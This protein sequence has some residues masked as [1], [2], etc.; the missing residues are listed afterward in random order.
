MLRFIDTILTWE[1]SYLSF[2]ITLSFLVAGLIFLF[3]PWGVLFKWTGRFLVLVLFGPQNKILDFAYVRHI[4]TNEQRIRKL[5][6]KRM[7][8]ARVVQEDNKKEKAF[9]NALFGK[10]ST[11]VP[12]IYWTR[13]HDFPLPSSYARHGPAEYLS[14]A[15]DVD[16]LPFVRGQLLKGVMIPRPVEAWRRNEA[17]SS[18]RKS[19]YKKSLKQNNGKMFDHDENT[20]LVQNPSG[21]LDQGFEVTDLYDE[22][23]GYVQNVLRE[24]STTELGVEILQN[25]NRAFKFESAFRSVH[26]FDDVD[27]DDD[28]SSTGPDPKPECTIVPSNLSKEDVDLTLTDW[29]C[30]GENGVEITEA[31]DLEAKFVQQ[32]WRGELPRSFQYQHETGPSGMEPANEDAVESRTEAKLL[33]NE[34]WISEADSA[35]E[36]GAFT[37]SE[38]AT[39]NNTPRMG[40]DAMVRMASKRDQGF[41]V[42]E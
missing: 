24:E 19:E 31:F 39:G 12:S 21:P 20:D 11:A 32:S 26:D 5:L 29:P 16:K 23:R 22:E 25:G 33:R 28:D 7:F 2:F 4:S 38:A 36:R 8:E 40:H 13:H 34:E 42:I 9:R 35:A 10:Y 27:G 17:E 1:E 41:E 30:G 18:K 37:D 3:V 6:R 14:R 15:E